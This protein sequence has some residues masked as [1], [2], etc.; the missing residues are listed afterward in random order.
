MEDQGKMR[1][2]LLHRGGASARS[3]RRMTGRQRGIRKTLIGP[4]QHLLQSP[5][6]ESW[7]GVQLSA[8]S[9]VLVTGDGGDGAYLSQVLAQAD[10]AFVLHWIERIA[11]QPF[12]LDTDGVI[13][14]VGSVH[15]DRLT[16]M[17]GTVEYADEL[18]DF[19]RASDQEMRR[20]LKSADGFEIRVCRPVQLVG[21]QQLDFIAAILAWWKADRMHD[22]QVHQCRAGSRAEVGRWA[23]TDALKPSGGCPGGFSRIRNLGQLRCRLHVHP[24]W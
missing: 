14:A 8:W 1:L 16:R 22:D 3:L 23:V 10:K 9:N 5:P 2:G 19:A 6:L 7:T 15:P 13:V 4:S 21:E 11:F 24:A 20:H 17:P 12:Q 18:N